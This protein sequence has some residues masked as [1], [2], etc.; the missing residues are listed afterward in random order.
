VEEVFEDMKNEGLL[1]AG[2]AFELLEVLDK[3]NFLAVSTDELN[4]TRDSVLDHL[5]GEV[6]HNGNHYFLVDGKFYAAEDSFIDRVKADF[7]SLL[8][9]E[10]FAPDSTLVMGDYL[11]THSSEGDYNESYIGKTGWLVADRAFVDNVEVADLFHWN[12]DK[13]YIIHNK[14]GYGVA[15][16]DVCSQILHSMK[17]IDRLKDSGDRAM[18]ENYYD[19]IIAK[20]YTCVTALISKED[21]VDMIIEIKKQNIIY[22]L[23]YAKPAAVDA[24]SRS[25][26]AKFE[27]IKLCNTDRKTFDF[28]LK[29]VHI[30]QHIL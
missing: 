9:G 19:K 6:E 18:I 22:V 1:P 24:R 5:H 29:V 10:Y 27:S 14:V 23:G 11:V 21:F 3:T 17:I 16:R 8:A 4:S 28:S 20:H 15:V 25:N 2:D 12:G 13:L 30:P 7:V 26:I